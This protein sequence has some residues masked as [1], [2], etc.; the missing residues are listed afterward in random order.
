MSNI[1]KRS[2]S[3]LLAVIMVVGMLPMGVLAEEVEEVYADDSYEE[4]VE[5]V[6]E[7]VV[8]EEVEEVEEVEDVEEVI[9]ED[10]MSLVTSASS[11]QAVGAEIGLDQADGLI[12]LDKS[13]QNALM[14]NVLGGGLRDMVLT[15][16]GMPTDG[17]EVVTYK[18]MDVSNPMNL[19][20]AGYAYELYD[21]ILAQEI[22]EFAID[23]E[24]TYIVCRN[25][26]NAVITVENV[27]I[28]NA[29]AP[30]NL[31]D[32]IRSA[33]EASVA[34]V[35]ITHNNDDLTALVGDAYTVTYA[36]TSNY[37]WPAAGQSQTYSGAVT[38]A[39][40]DAL[41]TME[42]TG[43][44]QVTLQ[45][46]TSCYTVTYSGGTNSFPATQVFSVY[47]GEATPA[48]VQPTRAYYTFTRW[49]PTVAAT[50]TE[51][52]TYNAVWTPIKDA[53]NDGT[54]D[55]EE[56]YTIKFYA[57]DEDVTSGAAYETYS[58]QYGTE[59]RKPDTKPT[60]TGYEFVGWKPVGGQLIQGV[61]AKVTKDAN[62]VAE[63]NKVE[64]P[65]ETEENE[66]VVTYDANGGQ[67][68]SGTMLY[69]KAAE[70]AATPAAGEEPTRTYYTFIGWEPEV[71]ATVTE[72]VTYK[73]VWAPINDVNSN[74][75][76]DEEEN[77]K[78]VTV[79]YIS[80]GQSFELPSKSDGTAELPA[81]TETEGDG[82][83]FQGWYF[84][85]AYET[86]YNGE[87]LQLEENVTNI[88]LY[89]KW[90]EDA[91]NNDKADGTAEDAYTTHIYEA[92]I[93]QTTYTES[94]TIWEQDNPDYDTQLVA[95]MPE[96][97][98]DT[99]IF[100]QWVAV[101]N[102][103][104][105]NP[106]NGTITYKPAFVEDM[107]QNSIADTDEIVEVTINAP[108]GFAKAGTIEANDAEVEQ[109][110]VKSGY[111]EGAESTTGTT[112]SRNLGFLCDN[113]DNGTTT[114]KV[115]P[116]M[117]N[118][119]LKTYI[120]AIKVDDNDLDLTYD[121]TDYSVTFTIDASGDASVAALTAD[122]TDVSNEHT[123]E[124][125]FASASEFTLKTEQ[126][127]LY[128]TDTYSDARVYNA[129]IALPE[130]GDATV[131]V[132]Y[133]ARAEQTVYVNVQELYEMLM[134]YGDIGET[135]WTYL[136]DGF[137][138]FTTGADG[139]YYYTLEL[140]AVWEDLYANTGAMKDPQNIADAY[141]AN[142]KNTPVT[143]LENLML[144]A[145][146]EKEKLD[147]ELSMAYIHPFGYNPN[148]LERVTET[149]KVIYDEPKQ[150]IEKDDVAVILTE[151][152]VE[153]TMSA[154]NMEGCYG[155][156]NSADIRNNVIFED[157]SGKTLNKANIELTGIPSSLNVG[158]YTIVASYAGDNAYMPSST[159]FTV[160]ITPRPVSMSFSQS[161]VIVDTTAVD[162]TYDSY[163]KAA[164]PVLS[165]ACDADVVQVIAGL[166][167][168]KANVNL[169]KENKIPINVTDLSAKAW[170]KISNSMKII[171]KAAG[172]DI[173][174]K[175]YTMD[176]INDMLRDN[177]DALE[178][179]GLSKANNQMI[180]D[181][182]AS[183]REYAEFD[184][185]VTF[186]DTLPE[187][188]GVY[189]NFAVIADSN[190]T[191][192]DEADEIDYANASNLIVV[193]PLIA[194][195]NRGDLQLVN[196]KNEAKDLFAFTNGNQEALKVLYKGNAV[197]CDVY[198]F[199]IDTSATIYNSVTTLPELPGVYV[200]AA[201]YRS[202]NGD[203]LASDAALMIVGMRESSVNVKSSTVVRDGNAYKPEIIVTNKEIGQTVTDA[204]L[205]VIS[206]TVDVDATDDLSLDSITGTI[207][208]DFPKR[209]ETK[210][211]EF[212]EY[213]NARTDK[214]QLPK[215]GNAS[216]EAVETTLDVAKAFL[217]YC[218]DVEV[219]T[220]KL[221][222]MGV[223]KAYIEKAE[224]YAKAACSKALELIGKVDADK[225]PNLQVSIKFANTN[226][227]DKGYTAYTDTG[228]YAYWA[229]TTD[230]DYAPALG[231]GL[232]VIKAHDSELVMYD[233]HVP[234]DGEG[235]EPKTDDNTS[236][237]GFSM[238]IDRNDDGSYR[239][240]N[241]L[242][243]ANM[244]KVVQYFEK[245]LGVTIIGNEITVGELKNKAGNWT[246]KLADYIVYGG[247]KAANGVIDK[248]DSIVDV[249]IH[250]T[251]LKKYTG[252]IVEA[253][254]TKLENLSTKLKA[255]LDELEEDVVIAGW[256]TTV[257]ATNG[258]PTE[259]GTYEF[260]T[261]S[262]A[263]VRARANLTIH[264]YYLEITPEDNQKEYQAEEPD[265]TATVKLYSY[266]GYG[267]EL[268]E[269]TYYTDKAVPADLAYTVVR[270]DGEDVG[271]YEMSIKE[272]SISYTN[273]GT[274][275][276]EDQV[277]TN[278]G[279]FEIT[280][281]EIIVV[282]PNYE[283]YYG[284][285]DPEMKVTAT[286]D[287][288]LAEG[289]ELTVTL[290][291]VSGATDV[292]TYNLNITDVVLTSEAGTDNLKNYN[293]VYKFAGDAKNATL[294][295]KPAEIKITFD[296]I[297]VDP[298]TTPVFTQKTDADD[299]N[300]W[301]EV[302]NGAVDVKNIGL[303][304]TA[305][306]ELNDNEV[307]NELGAYSINV[308][309]QKSA[310]YTLTHNGE[311]VSDD[312]GDV[313]EAVL[314][315][316]WGDYVCWN[317]E[318]GAY[319]TTAQAG[320]EAADAG[321]TVQM[322]QNSTETGFTNLADAHL[323]LNGFTLEVGYINFFNG[324]YIVDTS[325]NKTGLLKVPDNR[326]WIANNNSQMP[327]KM[328]S[329]DGFATYGFATMRMNYVDNGSTSDMYKF[330][331]KPSFG[332]A[333]NKSQFADGAENN[334]IRI[335]VRLRWTDYQDGDSKIRIQ[336]CQYSENMIK[337]V[338][339][340]NRSFT[341]GC[342][343]LSE[344]SDMTATVVVISGTNVE[345][346]G[347]TVPLP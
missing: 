293:I 91:N 214:V 246:E 326:M 291:N 178:A 237:D 234:Y 102:T 105:T 255:K 342:N 167:M 98:R 15:A 64:L 53:D 333:F 176:D 130:I 256:D 23:G 273:D 132:K 187:I 276:T 123:V 116:L 236:R 261:Y 101:S 160:T 18:D 185:D 193:R 163:E 100:V 292:G 283:K 270:A 9:E 143:Q 63:W 297:E 340:N 51:N 189:L 99:K 78:Q 96:T 94:H 177:A 212:V 224:Y 174:N 181:K 21:L 335:V 180:R 248:I 343:G 265:L 115:T 220:D 294:K 280:K 146:A 285:V 269:P 162:Y 30:D 71:A 186:Q 65:P 341:F 287:N 2:L 152:R 347:E 41:N 197:A 229:M 137:F 147:A 251:A 156:I 121:E 58:L 309:Y 37:A 305:P 328:E 221:A 327:I 73:A 54:A 150:H 275:C 321:Q 272:G 249:N 39:I 199:G 278:T 241:F 247:E 142:L 281:K 304:I 158:T 22:I 35:K 170:I 201:V 26:N 5:L 24:A 206:G 313:K 315:V 127:P 245:E 307:P 172:Y 62:Y 145:F 10:M 295:I 88:T 61:A 3:L 316:I 184:L 233:T 306:A 32:T 252:E 311:I 81:Y 44:A 114:V 80:G 139:D 290:K 173:E 149:L 268:P 93:G 282:V 47:D 205:T 260:H 110:N 75:T 284:D 259:I 258:L 104:E 308:E 337:D 222:S 155:T 154:S 95:Y 322:L 111:V 331:F 175:H 77:V 231:S 34:N 117:E 232:L 74:G 122:D 131:D 330:I 179:V 52:V 134:G 112:Y 133:L 46:N 346:C 303:K 27:T 240:V 135:A 204:A 72:N 207:N 76:A 217:E 17:D 317:T 279:T 266:D 225:L 166:D 86:K 218:V 29:G 314:Y 25:I 271:T 50:V 223:S 118:G 310:N 83:I 55:E 267:T 345:I 124:V 215:I 8:E 151:S 153:T 191:N 85:A 157:A 14:S 277:V 257:T 6:V 344:H 69:R 194:I 296:R 12:W 216:T 253:I 319:Y 140:E 289:S 254:D 192:A 334:D 203:K 165:P 332:T 108:E 302:I 48:A 325:A 89:A 230:L 144:T 7:E 68:T 13:N 38:V 263:L 120:A 196:S 126:D 235:H 182:L 59:T 43:K 301:I 312:A 97:N 129:V 66:Y 113:S 136:N 16:V 262:Y 195:P 274:F 90:A 211:D 209:L 138:H 19:A 324:S 200:A 288:G 20:I 168:T 31:A 339:G 264:P 161:V 33:L 198:Y 40:K 286:A 141:I 226:T 183:I 36:S 87:K 210:W 103:I 109:L 202:E 1:W 300:Y 336:D 148:A 190:Y 164:T 329:E 125:T 171:L 318:T 106:Y 320:V 159:T 228:V 67:F 82:V 250:A 92:L 242:L 243:D 107:N 227:K 239:K 298:F 70:D 238:V 188:S 4:V 119:V 213:F 169:D 56:N 244:K 28:T 11:A 42:K 57:T 208:I 219:P 60:R 79:T 49:D 338:Y 128:L 84:G 299:G 323:D 45:D